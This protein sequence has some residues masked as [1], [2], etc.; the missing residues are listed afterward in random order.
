MDAPRESDNLSA[1]AWVHEELRKS[2]ETAHK[3]LRQFLKSSEAASGSDVDAVDPAVLRTARLQ[4][5]QSVGAL[6]LVGLPAG[7][8]VLRASEAAVQ[9]FV[10]KPHTLQ[11]SAVEAIEK[12]SFALLDYIARLM[13]GKAISPVALF[14]QYEAVQMIAGAERIHPADLWTEDWQWRD[15]TAPNAAVAPR[16]ADVSTLAE[17]EQA[18]LAMMRQPSPEVSGRLA[19]LC[20][21][22][23]AGATGAHLR[24]LWHLGSAFF[25]AQAGGIL[26]ADLYTKRSA[27][28]LFAQ[29]RSQ[30][31]GSEDAPQRLAQDLLFFVAQAAPGFSVNA[32]PHLAAAR[33]AY[34]VD[35]AARVDYKST[36]LGRHDP[37]WVALARKRVATAKDAW[38]AVAAGEM[39]RLTGLTEQFSLVGESIQRLYPRGERLAAAL[40]AAIAQTASQGHTPPAPLAMEVATSVLYLEASLEDGEFD[41]PEEAQRVLRLA[42]RLEAV[43]GG[44]APEPLDSWMEEL[45]RRV[46]DRQTMGSVVHE[47]AASLGE[48]EKLIDQ[49]FRN[50]E[51]RN[52]LIPVPSQLQAMRGVLSVLGMDH[53]SA[54]VL[55]MRD[56]VDALLLPDTPIQEAADRG[57]FDRLATNLGALGFLIDMLNVQPHLAKSLFRFD[58]DTG[59]LSPLMGRRQEAAPVV[60][61][62]DAPR[63]MEQAQSVVESARQDTPLAELSLDLDRLSQDQVVS[64]QPELAA[65]ISAAKAAVESAEQAGAGPATEQMAREQVVQAMDDFMVTMSGPMGLDVIESPAEAP[66]SRPGPLTSPAPLTPLAPAAPQNVETGLEEDDEMRD[67]FLEEAREVIVNAT[68][69][70]QRLTAAPDNVEDITVI[71]RAFHTLKG[72]SRMVGLNDFGE[73]AWSWEQLYNAWLA[74][75]KPANDDLRGLTG[76]ALRSF[77][78]WTDEIAERRA[79]GRRGPPISQAADALRLEG[80]RVPLLPLVDNAEA[81]S[82][83]HAQP[84]TPVPALG[85]EATGFE[86]MPRPLTE[87]LEESR[88]ADAAAPEVQFEAVRSAFD[89]FD[90]VPGALDETTPAAVPPAAA[91]DDL[92]Q[93]KVIGSLRISIP[94]FNI[95]LNEADEHSRRLSTELAEWAH[96]FQQE[97]TAPAITDSAVALAHSLAGS[98]ATVGFAEL[99]QLSR[100]LEHALMRTQDLGSCDATDA[101]LFVDAAEEIRRLLHQFAAGFLKSPSPEI[102]ARL[103]HHEIDSVKR[104]EAQSR[105]T[106]FLDTPFEAPPAAGAEG[107]M[108]D[109]IALDL[110]SD[111]TPA[112]TAEPAAEDQPAPAEVIQ[113][114]ESMEPI[115]LVDVEPPAL[116]RPPQEEPHQEQPAPDVASGPAPAPAAVSQPMPLVEPETPAFRPLETSPFPEAGVA[117]RSAQQPPQGLTEYDAEIDAVDAV[118]PDLFPIFEEEAQELMPQLSAQ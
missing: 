109:L 77:S 35:P 16:V 56:D 106:D 37:A 82:G 5:H 44:S 23:A 39:H 10:A 102:I 32:A 84:A 80:K 103:Q 89:E 30:A 11:P 13:S 107:A 15:V 26:P 58:A 6:E 92:D 90:S 108:P 67:I 7:A 60:A 59:V 49:F 118:D 116:E 71:R 79:D 8:T 110:P 41:H 53:A 76:E 65:S 46:S 31:R 42:Q 48:A 27:S 61:L 117:S 12:S 34:G 85:T 33:E 29:L 24:D 50:T 99:S 47:L 87:S 66:V 57:V 63:L 70:L 111:A 64:Q 54:A 28:R 104:L 74:E 114:I 40:H 75:Q 19:Q 55:R 101:Q 115:E 88:P 73:A 17:F 68:D 25:E 45:Y 43:R 97:A 51:D 105:M 72:S 3:A 81:T 93:V 69:A 100:M 112:L 36:T 2:L 96:A 52:I 78:A 20:A 94:L 113:P 62:P 95:Y 21:G 83:Q 91:E 1:L 9:R 4:I 86:E 14:P 98:S 38:S 22:V 18:M